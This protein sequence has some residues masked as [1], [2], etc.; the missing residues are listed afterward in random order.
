MAG[1]RQR[2]LQP[3]I[4]EH[5]AVPFARLHLNDNAILL[6]A[7]VLMI[8]LERVLA[9]LPPVHSAIL[10]AATVLVLARQDVL[11]VPDSAILPVAMAQQEE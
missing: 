6:V 7:I 2:R 10:P 8:S 4:P 1:P 9:T 5:H 11:Q 3:V